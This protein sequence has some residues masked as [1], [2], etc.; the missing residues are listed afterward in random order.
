[1]KIY[2]HFTSD[3]LRYGR[4]IPAIGKWLKHDGK[5]KLCS[6][7]L[8]ASP[9]AYDA[10]SYAPGQMLH[11]VHMRGIA[12]REEDKVVG[13]ARKIVSTIDATALLRLFARKQALSCIHLWDCPDITKQYLETGDEGLR[14]AAHSAAHSAAQYVA[15]SAAQSAAQYAAHS[16]AHSAAW[17][18]AWSAALYAAQSAAQDAA[19]SAVRYAA[20][21]AVHS[22][23]HS[24]A[25]SAARYMFN[26]MVD[27]EFNR[28]VSPA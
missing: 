3:K 17:S 25:W 13:S 11:R 8:H 6:S 22:A 15:Q 28:Q 14:Y 7:G 5:V 27:E 9:T 21:S 1:M 16:A 24:A 4:R 10:L 23:A 2:Y 18:A 19:H 20:H 26:T 12:G